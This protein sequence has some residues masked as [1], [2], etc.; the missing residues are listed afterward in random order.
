MSG[1]GWHFGATGSPFKTPLP[2]EEH[3]PGCPGCQIARLTTA[4]KDAERKNELLK[5]EVDGMARAPYGEYQKMRER[6]ESAERENER[7]LEAE[8]RDQDIADLQAKNERLREV[9]RLAEA[10]LDEIDRERDEMF[11]GV[12]YAAQALSEALQEGVTPDGT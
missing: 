6:A 2:G 5:E 9:R 3:I 11:A 10:L 1:G 8:S 4:L 7:L 12:L